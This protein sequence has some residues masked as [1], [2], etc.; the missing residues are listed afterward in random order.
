[1]SLP[2]VGPRMWLLVGLAGQA[3][4]FSRFMVQWI[5]SERRGRSVIPT[6]FWY[7][8]LGGG[9]LLLIYAIHLGDPIFILGQSLGGVVY[10]RNLMLLR[11]GNQEPELM[12]RP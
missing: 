2:E 8:S 6:A 7:L 1:M 5:H 10:L 3:L 11:R 9:L 12:G 4:F